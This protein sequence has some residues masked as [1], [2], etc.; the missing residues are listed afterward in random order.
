MFNSYIQILT[1]CTFLFGK[2]EIEYIAPP[3]PDLRCG[4]PRQAP[5]GDR[6]PRPDGDGGGEQQERRGAVPDH[7]DAHQVRVPDHIAGRHANSAQ[8]AER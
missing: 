7:Q 2:F 8:E 6:P 1:N 5:R 4:L 3:L